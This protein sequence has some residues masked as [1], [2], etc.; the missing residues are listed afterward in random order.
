MTGTSLVSYQ[1]NV[2][3]SGGIKLC[4]PLWI[5]NLMHTFL[6]NPPFLINLPQLQLRKQKL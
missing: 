2:P 6:H 3:F 1:I 4:I 5:S